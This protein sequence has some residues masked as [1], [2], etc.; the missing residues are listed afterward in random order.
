LALAN[1]VTRGVDGEPIGD[2]TEIA[3]ARFAADAGL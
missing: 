3:L 1:D 2:P